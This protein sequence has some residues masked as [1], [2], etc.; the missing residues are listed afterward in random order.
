M[1]HY[2]L[3]EFEYRGMLDWLNS[4]KGEPPGMRAELRELAL[5]AVRRPLPDGFVFRAS[6]RLRPILGSAVVRIQLPAS[7][8]VSRDRR[9]GIQKQYAL[10]ARTPWLSFEP[11]W[12]DYFYK[13]ACLFSNPE[14]IARF[15]RCADC[16]RFFIQRKLRG[17]PAYCSD[18]CRKR[19][20]AKKSGTEIVRRCRFYKRLHGFLRRADIKAM[21]WAAR[22]QL[23]NDEGVG[24]SKS[25]RFRDTSAF[26]KA[27]A[28]AE[29][30][31]GKGL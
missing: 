15:S 17:E 4:D 23:W 29:A 20:Y 13:F 7:L 27:C 9:G 12:A 16:G 25:K 14:G 22:M 2:S 11:E 21:T 18:A 6:Q 5:E 30:R 31:F 19:G 26:R 24:R 10:R 3:D 8:V 28:V 1:R